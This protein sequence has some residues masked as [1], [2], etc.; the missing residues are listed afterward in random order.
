MQKGEPI[1]SEKNSPILPLIVEKRKIKKF[2]K[3]YF[4]LGWKESVG[5]PHLGISQ[6]IAKVDSGART[7]VIHAENINVFKKNR[8]WMVSFNVKYKID[9]MTKS[10]I[11]Q[12]PIIDKRKVYDSGGHTEN[13][14]FINTAL[15]IG[16]RVLSADFSLSDRS[17]MRYSMLLGR[18]AL[19][20]GYVIVPNKAF[21]SGIPISLNNYAVESK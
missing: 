7:S 3:P 17:S 19:C 13:R 4:L 11:C 12:S 21:L 8:K 18:M 2:R 1:E 10:I 9:N 5:L 20:N 15:K 6:I 14:V 16:E